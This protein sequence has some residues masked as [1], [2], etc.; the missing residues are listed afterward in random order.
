MNST[1]V[2]QN[3]HGWAEK[4]WSRRL[5]QG[6][7]LKNAEAPRAEAEVVEGIEE[8]GVR[9]LRETEIKYE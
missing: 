6:L 8:D 1:Y 3:K 2:F 7:A 4:W 5:L 9:F